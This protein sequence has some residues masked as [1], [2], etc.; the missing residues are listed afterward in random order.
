[1]QT[2]I[3]VARGLLADVMSS[4]ASL[5]AS[6]Q[7]T[8]SSIANMAAFGGFTSSFLRWGWLSLLIFVIYQFRPLYARYAAAT[9]GKI[10]L[11]LLF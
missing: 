10:L 2:E 6:V 4:A 8:S 11:L 9:I 3:Y 1:M 7:D 5:Q